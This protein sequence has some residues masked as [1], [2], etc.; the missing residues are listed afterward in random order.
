M[1]KNNIDAKVRRTMK[2][3]MIGSSIYNVALLVLVVIFTIIYCKIKNISNAKLITY[4]AKY[5]LSILIGY[6]YSIFC[7]YSMT[8]SITNSVDSN[9]DAFAKRHMIISTLVRLISF[10]IILVLLINEKVFG[11]VGGIMFLVASLGVKVGAYLTPLIE[12]KL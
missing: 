11:T 2:C 7:I 9:D 8:V 6:A 4:L 12:K 1:K 5:F 10:C 3:M